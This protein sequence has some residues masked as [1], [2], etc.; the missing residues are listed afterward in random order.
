[1]ITPTRIIE[2]PFER[3][4]MTLPGVGTR[5][6]CLN[7]NRRGLWRLGPFRRPRLAPPALPIF[8]IPGRLPFI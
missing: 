2:H 8:P 1:M 4:K 6:G 3:S 7:P 5:F